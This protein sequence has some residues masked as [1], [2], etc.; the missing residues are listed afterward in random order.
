MKSEAYF[1]SLYYS[2]L[3]FT[4]SGSQKKNQE[5]TFEI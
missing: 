1:T 5:S 2:V 4:A 3:V